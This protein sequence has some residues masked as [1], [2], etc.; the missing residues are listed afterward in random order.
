MKTLTQHFK[1]LENR[2]KTISLIEAGIMEKTAELD[3]L[4]SDLN[5]TLE[6]PDNPQVEAVEAIGQHLQE[7]LANTKVWLVFYESDDAD[8]EVV[9]EE[10]MTYWDALAS[11]AEHGIQLSKIV[12]DLN[13]NKKE[14]ANETD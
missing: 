8:G 14:T 9:T 4:K 6:A 10:P 12:L 13:F 1:T 7:V 11:Q 2:N 3:S 5:F